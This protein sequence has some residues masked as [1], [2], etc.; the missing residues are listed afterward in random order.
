MTQLWI[1]WRQALLTKSVR[2]FICQQNRLMCW[3]KRGQSDHICPETMSKN[4]YYKN[5]LFFHIEPLRINNRGTR[6]SLENCLWLRTSVALLPPLV[7]VL[8]CPCCELGM[9]LIL[10]S[11]PN[12]GHITSRTIWPGISMKMIKSFNVK[13]V[14]VEK[15]KTTAELL[16]TWPSSQTDLQNLMQCSARPTFFRSIWKQSN[17]LLSLANVIRALVAAAKTSTWNNFSELA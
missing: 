5:L 2:N 16:K 11:H 15:W 9:I 8:K 6:I 7:G 4:L 17:L 3:G 12:Y 14:T 1:N 10:I 13:V